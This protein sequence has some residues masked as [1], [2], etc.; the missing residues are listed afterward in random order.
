MN[1]VVDSAY[2]LLRGEIA[3][4]E[5]PGYC[6]KLVRLVVEDAYSLGSHGLYRYRSRVVDADKRASRDPYARDMEASLRDQGMAVSQV[7]DGP[8]VDQEF[9]QLEPGDL[10]FRF[11]V[12]KDARGVYIGH[13]GV[14][15]PGGLVLENVTPRANSLSRGYTCLTPLW[16]WPVTT[17][18]RFQP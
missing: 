13:V 11:D 1:P 3:A 5:K 16:T 17:V 14:L 7:Y 4:P 9:A 8:Y 6:L 18:V 10:L 15:M 12:A 2:K